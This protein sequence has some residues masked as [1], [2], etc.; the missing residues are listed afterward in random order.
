M[1]NWEMTSLSMRRDDWQEYART[2]RDVIGFLEVSGAAVPPRIAARLGSLQE[3]CADAATIDGPLPTVGSDDGRSIRVAARVELG[4][5]AE[6]SLAGFNLEL[7]KWLIGRLPGA[8]RVEVAI[9]EPR[10]LAALLPP[11]G[12]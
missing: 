7:R 2:L 10:P 12:P 8:Q 4:P 6:P 1:N 9:D 5:D 3:R 11:E